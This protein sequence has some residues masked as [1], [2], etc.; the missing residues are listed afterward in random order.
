MAQVL[1]TGPHLKLLSVLLDPYSSLL[2][3]NLHFHHNCIYCDF[4]L[5]IYSVHTTSIARLSVLGEESLPVALAEVSFIFSL[6]KVFF[7]GVFPCPIQ[8]SN[9]RF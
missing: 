6:L 5:L 3:Y 7:G 4:L 8:V 9:D 1:P 2:F